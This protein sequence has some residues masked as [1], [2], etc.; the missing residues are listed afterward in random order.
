MK[1]VNYPKPVTVTLLNKDYPVSCP[2]G[3]EGQLHE[4]A[5]VLNLKMNEIRNSGR[6]VS[7]E[8]IAIMAALNVTN[9]L[10]NYRRQKEAYIQ[11][12]TEQI[13]RLQNKI[14][15]ALL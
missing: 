13:D 4:A 8:R 10:L 9:E 5:Q 2:A 12:V 11:N 7:L 15:E 3:L 14:D 1:T 6:V